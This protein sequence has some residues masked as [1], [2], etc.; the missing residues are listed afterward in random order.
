MPLGKIEVGTEPIQ[1]LCDQLLNFW[2]LRGHYD[3]LKNTVF[4][5]TIIWAHWNDDLRKK[6]SQLMKCSNHSPF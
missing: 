1:D 5:E 6:K 2:K 3:T 4:H